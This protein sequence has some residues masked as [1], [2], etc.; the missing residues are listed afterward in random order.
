MALKPGFMAPS[1]VR[2]RQK[3]QASTGIA[4]TVG[5]RDHTLH[6]LAQHRTGTVPRSTAALLVV[7]GRGRDSWLL[8][9]LLSTVLESAEQ[10]VQVEWAATMAEA[11][12]RL[13]AKRWQAC[14]VDEQVGEETGL[15]LVRQARGR[16][17][18]VPMVLCIAHEDMTLQDIALEAGAAEVVALSSASA[19]KLG[20]V[21]HRAMVRG[22]AETQVRAEGDRYAKV[23]EESPIGMSLTNLEDGRFI[24]ANTAFCRLLGYSR[25]EVIG[26][27]AQEL[28]IWAEERGRLAQRARL[29]ASGTV[30]GVESLLQD[31]EGRLVHVLTTSRVMRLDGKQCVLAFTMDITGQSRAEADLVRRDMQLEAAEQA[32]GWGS[33]DLEVP[34]AR[35]RWSANLEA[36][37]GI[38]DAPRTIEGYLQGVVPEDREKVAEAFRRATQRGAPIKVRHGVRD[39]E[40][41]VVEMELQGMPEFDAQDEPI[42]LS[43]TLRPAPPTRPS[44]AAQG[45]RPQR[46][47]EGVAEAWAKGQNKPAT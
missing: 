12:E 18:D 11:L 33:W 3:G 13:P 34:T 27:T 30:E 23:F 14:L 42:A 24:D 37:L 45:G 10:Q 16:G 35:M 26:R 20:K 9:A 6:A 7:S 25:E 2:D 32:A 15:E 21:L 22:R 4:A 29:K 1:W 19:R 44:R 36:L 31:R 28:G 8:S 39:A 41:H 5:C 40:G 17:I 46:P 47:Q 43:G 38:R